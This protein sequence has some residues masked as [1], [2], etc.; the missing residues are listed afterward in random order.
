MTGVFC[1]HLLAGE[2]CSSEHLILGGRT[3]KFKA[4]SVRVRT[5]CVFFIKNQKET[6]KNIRNAISTQGYCTNFLLFYAVENLIK[7]KSSLIKYFNFVACEPVSSVS[8][9]TGYRLGERGSMPDR[10]RGFFLYRLRPDR[11]WGPPSLL[12]IGYSGLFPRG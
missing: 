2:H 10:I 12:Y 8:I 11:L 1:E 4:N 5:T 6:S 3:V 7:K 9:V